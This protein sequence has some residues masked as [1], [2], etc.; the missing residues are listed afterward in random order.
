MRDKDSR[1]L[2]T[3]IELYVADC[4][5]VSSRAVRDAGHAMST[6]SIR[7]YMAVLERLGYLEKTHTSAGRVPTDEAYRYYVDELEDNRRD[8]DEITSRCRAAL[9][10]D[11]RDAGE[12]MLNA[13]RILGECSKNFAV[14]YG[15]LVQDSRV[16]HVRLI[17]LDGPRVLVIVNLESEYERTTTIHLERSFSD[18]GVAGAERQWST[19]SWRAGRS[20]RRARRSTR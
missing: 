2:R 19:A 4:A 3:I 9:R 5:P 20:R 1:I 17:N 8:W 7:N 15:S 13:S 12:I 10:D 16:R 11:S 14:V 18:D 6:A